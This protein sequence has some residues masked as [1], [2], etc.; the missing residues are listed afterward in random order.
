M[1]FQTVD[2]YL[3]TF[4]P[5]TKAI[6]KQM[7]STIQKLVPDAEEVISYNMPGYNL[8]GMLVWFAGYKAH[9]GFYPKSAIIE[10][11]KDE[12]TPYKCSKGAIQFPL[13][14]PLP[15]PL[16]TKIVKKRI[17]ENLALAKAKDRS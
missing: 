13:D 7:R 11:L 2:Q 17:K 1:K 15:I 5:K 3:S 12:L 9:I 10:E 6:L 4:P 16:I 8:N 14:Q